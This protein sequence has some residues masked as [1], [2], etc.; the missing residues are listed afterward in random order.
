M[1]IC[2]K[3]RDHY[4]G[5]PKKDSKGKMPNFKQYVAYCSKCL[6]KVNLD[7]KR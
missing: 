7:E 6:E 2:R 4:N 5:E 3:L 1:T